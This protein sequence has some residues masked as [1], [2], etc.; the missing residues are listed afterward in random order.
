MAK[1]LPFGEIELAPP[2]LFFG[3][4][5]VLEIDTGSVPLN[6]ASPLVAEGHLVVK[7]PALFPISPPHARFMFERLPRRQRRAPGE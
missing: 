3:P 1:S 6:D 4:L 7:H 5:S 2:H